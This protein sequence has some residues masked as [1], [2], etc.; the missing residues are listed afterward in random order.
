MK[1][2][3]TNSPAGHAGATTLPPIGISFMYNETSGNNSGNDDVFVSWERID[4]IEITN[5]TFYYN[6]YYRYSIL[7]DDSKK[8]MG[9]FRIQLLIENNTWS[10]Q[11]TIA[12]N[13]EYSDNSTDWT[14]LNLDFTVENYG[15]K[16]IYDQVDTPHADMCFSNNTITHSVY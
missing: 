11:Y 4:I 9:R 16:L 7:I 13:D 3:K 12:K 10:T 6:R 1:S 5:I 8:S 2:T 14:L 15:I